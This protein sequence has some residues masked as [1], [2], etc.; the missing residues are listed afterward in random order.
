MGNDP[1]YYG[2]IACL[3]GV[4]TFLACWAYAIATY[5]WFLGGGLG[6]LPALC[7]AG[8]VGILWPLVLLVAL[9]IYRAA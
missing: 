6:W 1:P 7:I 8:L 2:C 4:P 9:L 3:F 5:G